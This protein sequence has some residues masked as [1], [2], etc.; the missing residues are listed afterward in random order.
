MR[1]LTPPDLKLPDLNT[2]AL[3]ELFHELTRDGSLHRL[4]LLA[5]DEDL[6][7][8]GAPGDITSRACGSSTTL[9]VSPPAIE[10]RLNAR[11][12]GVLAGAAAIP[13]LL[14]VFAPDTTCLLALRDGDAL[15]AGD[16]IATLRGPAA[17]VLALER[18]L[19][20]LVSRLSG[21]ASRTRLFARAMAGTS[22]R[23][24]DTR[25]TTPGWRG[26]EKYAVRCGGG[27]CHR[28]GLYDAM[29]IKDNHLASAGVGKGVEGLSSFV[30]QAIARAR[31]RTPA[32]R[33]VELEVDRLEQFEAVL[34]AGLCSAPANRASDQGSSRDHPQIDFVLLDNMSLAQLREAVALRDRSKAS[35]LLEASGGVTLETI[36][37]I[38]RTGV[39]RISVG[40]LTHHAVWLDLGLD[41]DPGMTLAG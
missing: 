17:Q 40:G 35:V 11:E 37:A 21:I 24:L 32:L 4:L 38:A 5:R 33:F 3:P 18:T 15:H 19:L 26:L 28:I 36:G 41:I 8:G 1:D 20:N 39:D 14:R 13:A 9:G 23:L 2:L 30:A 10:A 27:L 34:K 12:A 16:L 25:K 22:A 31:A 6:G 29:L 7:P